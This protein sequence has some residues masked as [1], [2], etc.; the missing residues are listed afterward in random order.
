MFDASLFFDLFFRAFA[1][2]LWM[3][4][5]CDDKDVEILSMKF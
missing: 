3:H 5:I 2:R 1:C 4:G